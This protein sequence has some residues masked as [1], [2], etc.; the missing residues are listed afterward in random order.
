MHDKA[1]LGGLRTQV[2]EQDRPG[3]SLAAALQANPASASNM[4]GPLTAGMAHAHAAIRDASLAFHARPDVQST[5]GRYIIGA[6][7]WRVLLNP[8]FLLCLLE[9]HVCAFWLGST[10]FRR[11]FD[12]VCA[13]AGVPKPLRQAFE[14]ARERAAASQAEPAPPPAAGQ[15][16]APAAARAAEPEGAKATAKSAKRD[17]AAAGYGEETQ[18]EY[19]AIPPAAKRA[20]RGALTEHQRETAARQRQGARHIH[21]DLRSSRIMPAQALY[22]WPG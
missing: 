10:G 9:N 15:Q 5:L 13:H 22:E 7:A 14:S 8:S 1:K 18:T 16:Q 17:C 3:M 12:G 2:A 4:L 6:L 20:K 11:E 19:V 21:R